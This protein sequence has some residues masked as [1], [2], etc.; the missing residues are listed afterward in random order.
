M[1]TENLK[2]GALL[3][4]RDRRNL[5][6]AAY[7]RRRKAKA[8]TPPVVDW[9]ETALEQNAYRMWANDQAGDCVFAAFYNL[10][11]GAT[12]QTGDP[13]AATDADCL[14]DYAA[15]TGYDLATGENDNGANPEDALRYYS[16]KTLGDQ[17]KILAWAEVDPDSLD[18]IREALHIFGGIYTAFYLP[19]TAQDQTGGG[20]VWDRSRIWTPGSV[21][22]TWGGHMT[23]TRCIDASGGDAKVFTVTWAEVQ[24]MTEAFWRR[25]CSAAYVIVTEK[26]VADNTGETP[27]GF[28]LETLL[29]DAAALRAA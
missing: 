25:Y 15:V 14:A 6:L 8:E 5:K 10:L 11:A 1:N 17:G 16:K 3:G 28:D 19:R 13:F 23:M 18:E 9:D 21:P 22:G 7:L 26:W 4:L 12:A 24:E 29:E 2:L 27:S 20:K